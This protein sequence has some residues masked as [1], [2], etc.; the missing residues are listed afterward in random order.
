MIINQF[1]MLL[2]IKV[3]GFF[4]LHNINIVGRHTGTRKTTPA[5]E[6]HH[7]TTEKERK[8]KKNTN[9]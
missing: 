5:A 4:R 7:T 8:E 2:I 6:T 1:Q 3:R 9:H